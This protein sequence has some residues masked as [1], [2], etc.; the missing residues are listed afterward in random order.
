MKNAKEVETVM[1][2]LNVF[3]KNKS[4]ELKGI[5]IILMLF[6]HCFRL[7]KIYDGCAVSFYPFSE[8][9]VVN[10][11]YV[12]KICVSFFAFISGYGLFLNYERK[13]ES[14]QKWVLRRYVKTFSGYWLIWVISAIICQIIDGRTQKVF[15]S[16]G[17]SKG[18]VYCILNIIGIDNLFGTP[19]LNDVWWYMGAA[20]VFIIL[21][22]VIYQCKDNLWLLLAL[23]IVIPRMLLRNNGTIMTSSGTSAFSFFVPLVLG[24]IFARYSLFE[25][26]NRIS[27]R[28]M[29]YM[30]LVEIWGIIFF[31]KI[32][33]Y[34]DRSKY[35]EIH[36]GIF[37]MICIIFIVEHVLQIKYFYKPLVTLGKHSMNIYLIHSF[38][39]L[40]LKKMIFSNRHF[41]IITFTMIVLSL[42]ASIIIEWFK[43]LFRY[44]ERLNNLL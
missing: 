4:L 26:I 42:A 18:T 17:L 15:F 24:C 31:Y 20:S 29:L 37:P 25:R 3:D 36:Y 5:A 19:T 2:S 7:T 41:L 10:A 11:A 32:Y 43:Q 35:W 12:S 34:M 39:Q 9:S 8:T 1:D 23:L 14:A 33:L 30:L 16:G 21:I 13:N 40:Y 44:N 6:H 22:P 27:K 28:T 38:I